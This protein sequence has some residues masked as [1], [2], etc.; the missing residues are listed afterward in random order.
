MPSYLLAW[1]PKRWVWD[2]LDNFVEAFNRGET[3]T[4]TWSCSGNKQIA[5]GDS[6]WLIRLGEEPRGIF[7]RGIVTRGSYEDDHWS[8]PEKTSRYVDFEIDG[9][10]N[11]NPDPI[12]TLERLH[13]PPFDA[14]RWSTQSSGIS[15]PDDVSRALENEWLEM[16]FREKNSQTEEDTATFARASVMFALEDPPS[17]TRYAEVLDFLRSSFSDRELKVLAF[18]F[19]QPGRAVTSQDIRDFF[20]YSSIGSSNLLYGTL[21]KKLAGALPMR[22]A[23]EGAVP[24]RYWKALA[25]GDGSGEHFLWTMRPQLATALVETGLVENA[26]DGAAMLADIDIH[27]GDVVANEGRLQLFL[28]LRR[29]RNQALV[30]AKKAASDSHACE[31]CGFDSIEVYG[32]DYC[33]VHH[34]TP[35]SELNGETETSLDDLAILCANCHR[36]LHLQTPPM[37]L[38]SL[39]QKL[40]HRS[41]PGS[42]GMLG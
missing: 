36:V 17:S 32:I 28:H 22:T 10:V 7:C 30:A 24:P 18:Q 9:I 6:V 37:P 35:I 23:E 16:I 2:D 11:P 42:L 20:G 13:E 14:V 38:D 3:R 12:I 1:N 5:A 34:L 15:I 39:R 26:T 33:E 41:G 27:P 40:R 21:G 25:T 29:E 31:I 19:Q 4:S 8:D